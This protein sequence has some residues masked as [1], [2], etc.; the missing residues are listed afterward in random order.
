MIGS[1]RFLAPLLIVAAAMTRPAAAD[2]RD[3]SPSGFT[4]ENSVVVPV[5]AA[6]AWAALVN[7]VDAWWPK[8]HS[9]WG[10]ESK[11]TIDARA[12]GCFCEIAGERQA[13]HLQVVFADPPRLLRLAGALGPM[14]GMG[15]SG[16]Q[17][18]R[19]QAAD[20]GTR[21]TLW[22]RAGG[23]SPD[24]LRELAPVVNRVQG[25]QLGGLANYLTERNGRPAQKS[26]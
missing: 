3:S 22:Y 7:D 23:Y 6:T 11:L 19:L 15:L 4:V 24:D 18:W 9:W 12:G 8:D 25:L 14:Q 21:I 13:Q 26:H 5:N 10:R 2:V 17:E 1:S 20:G 16:V